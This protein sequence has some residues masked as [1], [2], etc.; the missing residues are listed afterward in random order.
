MHHLL[1][2][3]LFAKASCFFLRLI[4]EPSASCF[5]TQILMYLLH[6]L[7]WLLPSINSTPFLSAKHLLII[8][9]M[10]LHQL[11]LF[12]ILI[13]IFLIHSFFSF[14]FHPFA[15]ENLFLPCNEVCKCHITNTIFQRFYI[16]LKQLR[17]LNIYFFFLPDVGLLHWIS[18]VPTY[19]SFCILTL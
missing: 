12:T 1:L 9:V 5:A 11:G 10:P 14:F 15:L 4:P 6:F 7:G 8:C 18:T 19:F 3:L 16:L 2:S 13:V 17:V